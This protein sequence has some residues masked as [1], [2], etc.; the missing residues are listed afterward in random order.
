MTNFDAVLF[1]LDFT[2]CH[3]DQDEEIVLA[4]VFERASIE[5]DANP[6]D[7]VH[8]GDSLRAD[9][10]GARPRHRFRVG[11]LRGTNHDS[12]AR[13]DV[14]APVARGIS[15]YSVKISG[16]RRLSPTCSSSPRSPTE[17]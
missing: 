5:L 9:V 4:E 13:T 6:N 8:V 16:I 12:H 11:P 14:H 15:E 3:S 1:D 2:L 10:A 7:V 17:P